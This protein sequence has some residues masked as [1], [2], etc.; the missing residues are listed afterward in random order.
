VKDRQDA[1]EWLNARRST[2]G[3]ELEIRQV[4]EAEEFG[5]EFTPEAR[6]IEKRAL[7]DAAE[8]QVGGIR[9]HRAGESWRRRSAVIA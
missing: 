6:A 9:G 5:E 1:I 7:E 4:F 8:A 2:S 3:A